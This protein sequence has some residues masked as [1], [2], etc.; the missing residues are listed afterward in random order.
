M[1][2]PQITIET[3]TP[4]QATEML[5]LNTNNRSVRTKVVDRYASDMTGGSFLLTG[6]PIIINGTTLINGQHRL[7]AC[8]KAGVPF[9]TAVFRG[10]SS[11]VYAVVD[12][13]LTR[14]PGDVLQHDGHANSRVVAAA[15]RLVI[16]YRENCLHGDT[17]ALQIAAS[18]HAMVDE[19][20]THRARYAEF[21]SIAVS[22]KGQGFNGSALCAFGIILGE[23]LSSDEEAMSWIKSV[24]KGANLDERDPRLAL[25]RWVASSRSATNKVHLSAFIRAHNAFSRN[26][27]RTIIKSWFGGTPFPRLDES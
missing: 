10:A 12:S 16:G 19:C 8:V 15:A 5:T 20:H 13:G 17:Y 3:I 23:H 26:E 27:G 4:E 1:A 14:Q 6:E 2:T 18:R 7:L 24:V 22:S 21:S 9:T 25:R 11:D